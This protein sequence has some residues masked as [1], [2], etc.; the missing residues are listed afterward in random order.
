MRRE[1][2]FLCRHCRASTRQSMLRNGWLTFA[3]WFPSPH[4]SMDHRVKP[5][6]DEVGDVGARALR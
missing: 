1:D 3:E 6:G 2:D 4:F 5:G